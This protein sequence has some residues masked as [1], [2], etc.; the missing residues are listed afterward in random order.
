MNQEQEFRQ[1]ARD[2]KEHC[3]ALCN[4]ESALYDDGEECN[5]KSYTAIKNPET[6][7]LWAICRDCYQSLPEGIGGGARAPPPLWLGVRG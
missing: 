2:G 4:E 1:S 3:E 6:G 5:R 7:A